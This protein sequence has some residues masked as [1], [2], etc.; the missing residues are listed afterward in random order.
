MKTEYRDNDSRLVGDCID[1]DPAAWAAFIKKYSRLIYISI[2]NRL[3]KYGI[4][5]SGQDIEDIR[6]DILASLWGHS[7]LESIRNRHDISYW[8]AVTCGNMAIEYVRKRRSIDLAKCLPLFDNIDE[9]DLAELAWPSQTSA[10]DD[11]AREELLKKAQGLIKSLPD[12]ERLIIKLNLIHGK[13]YHEI[14]D[15]LNMP[16]GTVSSYIK[17]AKERLKNGLRDFF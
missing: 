3:K 8:L 15:I 16:R 7:K 4:A 9:G 10:D 2:N 6:Q 14:A 5:M 17:R 1:R 13:K 11:N 12:K